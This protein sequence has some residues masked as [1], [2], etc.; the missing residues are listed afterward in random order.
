MFLHQAH[1]FSEVVHSVALVVHIK[2]ER[3]SGLK[4]EKEELER[5]V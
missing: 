5:E 4:A 2:S 1:S 3:N